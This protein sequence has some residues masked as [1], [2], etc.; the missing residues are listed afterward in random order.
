[1]NEAARYTS[2]LFKRSKLLY[3]YN[4]RIHLK[5]VEHRLQEKPSLKLMFFTYFNIGSYTVM[6]IMSEPLELFFRTLKEKN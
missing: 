4:E 6:L 3:Y 2:Q 5:I 1:M